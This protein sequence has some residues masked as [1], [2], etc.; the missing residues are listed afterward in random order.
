VLRIAGIRA[1]L[2][3]VP[4]ARSNMA[5]ID[6]RQFVTMSAGVALASILP[7]PGPSVFSPIMAAR[8]TAMHDAMTALTSAPDASA[9]QHARDCVE[10]A[11]MTPTSCAGDEDA[12]MLALDAYEEIHPSAF[13]MQTARDLF[14]PGRHQT[15]SRDRLRHWLLTDPDED[16]IKTGMPGFLRAARQKHREAGIR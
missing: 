16:F 5:I 10:A 14:T 8:I 13:W 3:C 6:R 15:Y 1:S 2:R 4:P 9:V 7:S 12:V 11:F